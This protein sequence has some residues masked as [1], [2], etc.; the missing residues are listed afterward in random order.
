MDDNRFTAEQLDATTGALEQ[1]IAALDARIAS[2]SANLDELAAA[3]RRYV[4]D[5]VHA[6]LPAI[7]SRVLGRL[8][9]QVPRFVGTAVVDAFNRH[10]K[11]FG[12]FS[13][14][15]YRRALALLRTRLSQH[16]EQHQYG[17]LPHLDSEVTDARHEFDRLTSQR[18][19]LSALAMAVASAKQGRSALS[20]EKR[21]ALARLVPPREIRGMTMVR[22]RNLT[23]SHQSPDSGPNDSDLLLYFFTDI[24]TSA[25]TL[26]L[27]LFRDGS[28]HHRT[29]PATP[30][31]ASSVDVFVAMPSVGSIGADVSGLADVSVDTGTGPGW[32][33]NDPTP[34]VC[35]PASAADDLGLF[36]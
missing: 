3:R 7:H 27:D 9:E 2:E 22:R 31:S 5:T 15:G 13:G 1:A 16:L 24:P 11:I 8:S 29:D 34:A 21:A 26:V 19:E 20:D 18:A 4:Q 12:I 6:L 28:G 32:S 17:D 30:A 14:P 35:T 33:I 23:A 25:R 36:S 10:R